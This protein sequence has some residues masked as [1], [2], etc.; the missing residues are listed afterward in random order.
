[1]TIKITQLL[2]VGVRVDP[3][4]NSIEEANTFQS[5]LLGLELDPK[6]PD[7]RDILS[8]QV[9]ISNGARTQQ[10]HVMGAAGASP[11]SRS[12]TEDPTRMHMVFAVENI[13]EARSEL[14]KKVLK[15][16]EYDGLVG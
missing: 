2:H 7:I 12:K 5:D 3:D 16:W 8:S 1:M 13:N 15:Y 14:A 10:V 9:N 6:R 4:K 11:V